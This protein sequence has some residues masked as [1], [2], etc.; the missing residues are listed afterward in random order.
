MN[1]KVMAGSVLALLVTMGIAI[2]GS[3]NAPF[4]IEVTVDTT[5]FIPTLC[6]DADDTIP[7]T[8]EF[9]PGI[10]GLDSEYALAIDSCAD[11][12]TGDWSV[13]MGGNVPLNLSFKLNTS[14]ISGITVSICNE[15]NS[16][17]TFIQ[18]NELNLTG[19]DQTPSWAQDLVD[20]STL[21]LWQRVAADTTAIGDKSHDRHIIVTSTY[22]T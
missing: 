16:P 19:A 13:E 14:P 11:N 5:I 9:H 22:T 8:L 4:R 18:G 7:N 2:A 20:A 3:G 17:D 6:E 1:K 15:N 21:Q 12:S 10:N